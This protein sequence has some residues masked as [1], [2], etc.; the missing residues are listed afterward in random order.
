MSLKE[1]GFR[2]EYRSLL[3]DVIREFYIPALEHA[4]LYKR[5]VGF[6]SSTSLIQLTKGLCKLVENGGKI[7]LVVSPVLSDADIQAIKDGFDRR[8][9]IIEQSLLRELASHHGR[10]DEERLNFLSNLIALGRLEI[11][12]AILEEDK[13]IGMFHEKMGLIYDAEGNAVAFSGS[14]NESENAFVRNYEAIDVFT[15][16]S[17]DEARVLQ[18]RAAFDAIWADCEPHLRVLEFPR[19][20]EELFRRYRYNETV[21]VTIDQREFL[22]RDGCYQPERGPRVPSEVKIR[23]Y[24]EEAIENWARNGFRGIFDMAT[25]T[26]KT[27]TA[28]A[29]ISRLYRTTNQDLAVIIICPYQHLVEQWRDDIVKFGMKPILCY[30]SSSQRDWKKRLRTAVTGFR[31][32][33]EN[34]FCMVAT[35]A[36][37]SSDYVQSQLS[38]LSG[39]TL[40]VVD[41]AHNFGATNLRTM[42]LPNMSFRL[43]LSA[44][45]DR[46]RDE[47]GT[48]KL[49]EYFG[50]KCIEYT[51]ND[52]IANGMLVPYYYYPIIVSLSSDELREYLE[53]T[54]RIKT[55]TRDGAKLDDL[56]E[57]AKMLLIKRAR[58]VASAS[59]KIPA[60]ER[61]IS[62]HRDES[63]ILVYCGAT[64]MRDVDYTEGSAPADEVKQINVVADLLGNRLGMRISK[65]T[66]EESAEE[67]EIIKESFADGRHIQ[68]LVAIRCLDEGVNVPSI[69]TA[70]ILASST[71]PKEYIQRRGRVLRKHP[72]KSRAVIYDF[73]TLPFSVEDLVQYPEDVVLNAKSL[74][75][76]EIVR[77]R[78]FASISENPSIV[79]SLITEIVHAYGIERDIE[80][81]V[82]LA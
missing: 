43:A 48:A 3:T 34:H 19:V 65:F 6:F 58:L 17:S 28:L 23:D 53:L 20:K 22:V 71:N 59:E 60:L 14:M 4:V 57:Y 32:G 52:A 78:E 11:K 49:Y 13:A 47:E 40:L 55:C 61:A 56:S 76:R 37:F 67:R 12:V 66:S 31:L 72:G 81:G 70:F 74:A 16:W 8:Y 54:R 25:G 79:D 15:S 51:L 38:A 5:A 80:G 7:Q 29:A 39:N 9:Q 69:R 75:V 62:A 10:F 77:M 35:N 42:L 44:T 30:S 82:L 63:H 2:H 45:I 46:Y 24:Q 50:D 27:Y 26:G 41:E 73:I 21:D 33:V 68:A 36:T 1:I 18:K 64:T